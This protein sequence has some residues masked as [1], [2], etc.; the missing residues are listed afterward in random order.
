MS[1]ESKVLKP[2]VLRALMLLNSPHASQTI[3]HVLGNVPQ[4]RQALLP[5]AQHLMLHVQNASSIAPAISDQALNIVLTDK[6]RRA[7]ILDKLIKYGWLYRDVRTRKPLV[8][9]GDAIPENSLWHNCT[10]DQVV[11]WRMLGV[12]KEEL[13]FDLRGEKINAELFTRPVMTP[14]APMPQDL[15]VL[16]GLSESAKGD[17]AIIFETELMAQS[18]AVTGEMSLGH[19]ALGAFGDQSAEKYRLIPTAEEIR[20]FVQAGDQ[21]ANSEMAERLVWVTQGFVE[22][23]V[24]KSVVKIEDATHISAA[25]GMIRYR[26]DLAQIDDS[27]KVIVVEA[28]NALVELDDYLRITRSSAEVRSFSTA[29]PDYMRSGGHYLRI[30][31]ELQR[32]LSR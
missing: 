13:A 29:L 4:V 12:R 19:A 7:R 10:E 32:A 9:G 18:S 15:K 16:P 17:L 30:A 27:A 23:L 11:M 31:R 24:A 2:G 6:A 14:G 3:Q 28:L 25:D 5:F 20:G 8:K 21:E 1:Q 22:Q 26:Y